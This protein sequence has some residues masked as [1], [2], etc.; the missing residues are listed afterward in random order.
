MP[1]QGGGPG[2]SLTLCCFMIYSTRQFYLVSFSS[3][4]FRPFSIA[5]TS[6]R[7]ERV[8][9]FSYVC[10]ICACLVLSVPSSSWCLGRAAVCDCGTP[11]KSLNFFS[12]V[13]FGISSFIPHLIVFRYLVKTVLSDFFIF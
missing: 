5:I 6:L 3:C 13:A 8:K 10:S 11:W 4:V 7:D 2:V 12:D 1:F 9:C